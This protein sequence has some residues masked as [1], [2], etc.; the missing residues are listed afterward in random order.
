MKKNI[1]WGCIIGVLLVAGVFTGCASTGGSKLHSDFMLPSIPKEEHAILI[2]DPFIAIST[3]NGHFFSWASTTN[4]NQ[5]I[6]FPAGTYELE[7]WYG[8]TEV[9]SSFS[10]NWNTT[11]ISTKDA[12]LVKCDFAPG[13]YYSL[14]A[15]VGSNTITFKITEETDTAQAKIIAAQERIGKVKV[16]EPTRWSIGY[17]K[18]EPTK[19][20]GTWKTDDGEF[21]LSFTGNTYAWS[22]N[23]MLRGN[24]NFTEN[25]M[26]FYPVSVDV[27]NGWT[28]MPAKITQRFKY[29]LSGNILTVDKHTLRKQS[30]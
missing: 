18:K 29:T 11:E 26:I 22:L 12:T 25:T 6:P 13:H 1:F 28:A 9:Y 16:K 10:G 8:K 7:V 17:I 24:F 15:N 4:K 14:T 20:E 30:D 27:G 5:I 3:V 23:G 2:I 21:E 19:F